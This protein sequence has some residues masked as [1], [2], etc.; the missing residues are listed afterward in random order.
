MT[1]DEAEELLKRYVKNERMLDHSIASEAILRALARRLGRDEEKWGLA[2]L[3][4]DIDIEVVERAASI[5]CTPE[6]IATVCKVA[7]STFFDRMKTHPEV[8]DAIDRGREG[9]ERARKQRGRQV[10]AAKD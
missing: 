1:R 8:A 7:R 5:G 10:C 2:G 4:H 6:E 9:S 3:L